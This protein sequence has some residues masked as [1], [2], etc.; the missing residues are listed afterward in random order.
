MNII[1]CVKIVPEE[2]DIVVKGDKTLSTDKAASKIGLYDLNA[3]EA[4]AELAGDGG[5]VTALTV[6]GERATASK[7]H[8]D[9]LSRGADELVVVSD[10]SLEGALPEV[11]SKVLAAALKNAGDYDLILCGE[12]SSDLYA[13]ITGVLAAESLG[14]PVVN[15]V[16]KINADGGTVTVERTLDGGSEEL[17]VPLPAVLCVSSDINTPRIPN[18]KAILQAGK[19]PKNAMA[20]SDLGVSANSA[21]SVM[22]SIL[23]PEQKERL[24]NIIEGDSDDNLAAFAENLRKALN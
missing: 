13:Q 16:S 20:L 24:Q 1:V 10:P 17:S 14:V 21:A 15:C 2:Q 12:G 4:A 11:T 19:K 7:T 6:G 3:L 23:A 5:K 8:K 22:Q 9:I 18:M